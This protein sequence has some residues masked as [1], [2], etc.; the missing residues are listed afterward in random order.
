M[1]TG[2]VYNN[3]ATLAD[4]DSYVHSVYGIG[5]ASFAN[6]DPLHKNAELVNGGKWPTPIVLRVIRDLE[7][8]EEVFLDYGYNPM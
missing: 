1:L 3:L 4:R 8:G 2:W 6:H 5:L 7:P